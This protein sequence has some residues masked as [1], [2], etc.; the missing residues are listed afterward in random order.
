MQRPRRPWGLPT[1]Y[2]EE[3]K[4]TQP[5]RR[6]P[7]KLRAE[8]EPEKMV[9]KILDQ[10]VERITVRELIGFLPD[11][12]RQRWGAERF[13]ALKGALVELVCGGACLVG[14]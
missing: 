8:G 2:S 10:S 11:F 6:V 7:V 9:N 4:G 12:L 14:V 13:P 1:D 5:G 3:M